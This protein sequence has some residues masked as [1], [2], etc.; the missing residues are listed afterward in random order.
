LKELIQDKLRNRSHVLIS[1][2]DELKS[3]HE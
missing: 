2:I 3:K 1:K